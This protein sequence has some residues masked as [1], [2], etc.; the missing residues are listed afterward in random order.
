M[1]GIDYSLVGLILLTSYAALDQFRKGYKVKKKVDA[2][3][4]DL[5]AGVYD[6]VLATNQVEE[7]KNPG[8]LNGDS[9]ENLT[10]SD[11]EN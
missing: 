2:A 8:Y 6:D 5:E 4:S 3:L 11:Y 1:D 9:L 10:Q 7:Q